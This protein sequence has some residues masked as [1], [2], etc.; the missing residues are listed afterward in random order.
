MQVNDDRPLL[1]YLPLKQAAEA[2]H[3]SVRTLL[4]WD[5]QR[6]LRISRPAGP[7]ASCYV[8]LADVQ[9]F[10]QDGF[11]VAPDANLGRRLTAA[12]LQ[13]K[14]RSPKP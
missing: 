11:R 2:L 1:P 12:R 8:A 4:R 7:R 6:L 3:V 14:T 5:R 10:I 9:K 13:T